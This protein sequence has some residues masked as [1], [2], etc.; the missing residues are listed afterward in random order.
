MNGLKDVS[1][2]SMLDKAGGAAAG[3]KEKEKDGEQSQGSRLM[4][5]KQ[6]NQMAI[7]VRELSKKLGS[8]RLKMKVKTVF[9]LTKIHDESLVGK[10]R[11][12]AAWLL[13]MERDTPYIVLVAATIGGEGYANDGIATWRLFWR[14]ILFLTRRVCWHRIHLTRGA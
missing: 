13:D 11:E 6:L 1:E 2:D 14:S 10:T 3:E 9:L 4:T 8:V 12:L 7:G 5:K